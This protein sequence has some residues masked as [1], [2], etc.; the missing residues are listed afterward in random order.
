MNYKLSNQDL[1]DIQEKLS[2]EEILYIEKIKTQKFNIGDILI[3][4]TISFNDDKTISGQSIQTYENSLLY[5]RFLVIHVDHNTNASFYKEVMENGKLD[6][7]L[8]CTI[9][10]EDIGYRGDM[11]YF[12]V[13]P[14]FVDAV[15]FGEEFDLSGLLK[16][17]KK[18]K[19]RLIKMN[20]S[21]AVTFDNLKDVNNFIRSLSPNGMLYYHSND[22]ETFNEND[23][24]SLK[25]K[26]PRKAKFNT[27]A[28]TRRFR[29]YISKNLAKTAL[30]DSHVLY[31]RC[32]EHDKLITSCE[33]IGQA[34]YK[35]KPIV[36]KEQP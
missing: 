23:F 31:L 13:D 2:S 33:L 7:E 6:K 1:K 21:T 32:L 34:L 27:Y 29:R 18:R 4:K 22:K 30:N 35:V 8:A 24:I 10:L 3:K 9:C 5:R 15:I 28:Q 16:E 36:L 17:E 26:K 11:S 25:L 20:R 19:T 14:S 12:E